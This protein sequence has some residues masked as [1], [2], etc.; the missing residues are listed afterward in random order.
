MPTQIKK[1][2]AWGGTVRI[3]EIKICYVTQ[4]AST[5]KTSVFTF[6]RIF[7]LLPR[8]NKQVRKDITFIAKRHTL[9]I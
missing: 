6:L 8:E 4:H 3:I 2:E 1:K 9:L 7:L 5:F